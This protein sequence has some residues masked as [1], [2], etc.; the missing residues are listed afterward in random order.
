MLISI[1]NIINVLP[2][3][4]W[5]FYNLPNNMQSYYYFLTNLFVIFNLNFII[6]YVYY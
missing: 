4:V 5:T 6:H 3:K 1:T 2:I